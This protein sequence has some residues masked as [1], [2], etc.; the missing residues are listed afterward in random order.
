MEEIENPLVEISDYPV[1]GGETLRTY[2]FIL[3]K[4]HFILP[5]FYFGPPWGIFI[6]TEQLRNSSVELKLHQ[7]HECP[8]VGTHG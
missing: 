4:F 2:D 7:S 8:D 6:S 1:R 5:K 3:P